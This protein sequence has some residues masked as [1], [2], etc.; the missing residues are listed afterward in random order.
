MGRRAADL[1]T[2]VPV[3]GVPALV[4][5][6]SWK[7]TGGDRSVGGALLQTYGIQ[8]NVGV[9]TSPGINRPPTTYC[10]KLP[11]SRVSVSSETSNGYFSVESVYKEI[12]L[13]T[14]SDREKRA[15]LKQKSGESKTKKEVTFKAGEPSKDV[16]SSRKSS[17]TYCYA[18]AI[19]TNP[20]L[21]GNS[22]NVR[23]KLKSITRYA[24]GS[25][26]DSEAIGGISIDNGDSE[27][28]S[29]GMDLNRQQ[30]HYAEQPGMTPPLFAAR[31]FPQKICSHC[32]GRQSESTRTVGEKSTTTHACSGKTLLNLNAPNLEKCSP[33]DAITQFFLNQ[34]IC[35][36]N[37]DAKYRN[38]PHP[39][40]PVHSLNRSFKTNLTTHRA[41]ITPPTTFFNSRSLTVTKATIE[42]RQCGTIPRPTSLPLTPLMATATKTNNTH[43]NTYPMHLKNLHK[44]T[45]EQHATSN[46]SKPCTSVAAIPKNIFLSNDLSITEGCKSEKITSVKTN[47]SNIPNPSKLEK[48]PYRLHSENTELIK[49]NIAQGTANL[50]DK[51]VMNTTSSKENPSSISLGTES[52]PQKATSFKVL[53]KS[54]SL[55]S[56]DTVN[57]K[58]NSARTHAL[59]YVTENTLCTHASTEHNCTKPVVTQISQTLP[60]L[61]TSTTSPNTTDNQGSLTSTALRST[62]PSNHTRSSQTCSASKSSVSQ[63]ALVEKQSLISKNLTSTTTTQENHV[64]P[65]DATDHV[66]TNT[67]L[68]RFKP[69]TTNSSKIQCFTDERKCNDNLMRGLVRQRSQDHKS[70]SGS[71]V[72]NLQNYISLIKSSSSCL[73]GHINTKQKPTHYQGYSKTELEGRATCPPVKTAAQKDPNT[74]QFALGVAISHEPIN[75]ESG[76]DERTHPASSASPV[77]KQEN[78]ISPMTNNRNSSISHSHLLSHSHSGQ[79]PASFHSKDRPHSVLECT[80]I[81]SSP[82]MHLA[83]VHSLEPSEAEE[84]VKGDSQSSFTPA[85]Q[86]SPEKASL[87]H[88]HPVDAAM[89][90]PASPQSCG[91]AALQQRLEC[92]EA[93]LAANKDRITTLLNIIHD[94]ETCQTPTSGYDV[95]MCKGSGM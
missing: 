21:A 82:T 11:E 46:T 70:S 38:T 51:S 60:Q 32:G 25:V 63:L 72:S 71:Q 20:Q 12:S 84:I 39:A 75:F 37:D 80:S 67:S 9:Q 34:Q 57:P 16:A 8:C 10:A 23:P 81:L 66:T 77:T 54:S 87:A 3:L 17:G 94:L 69:E 83:S 79:G 68:P 30:G 59:P 28:A 24:N 93:S 86:W 43:L 2:S 73:Q 62:L 65:N 29:C 47:K 4:G 92:V 48:E 74:E 91:S 61:C 44:S 56:P 36:P 26:V 49:T 15:I 52:A 41:N 76:R 13:L 50:S 19:K 31:P 6:R 33:R 78:N 14:K 90:L 45:I 58:A 95:C 42:T 85:P 27:S 18:R 40:C 89:M 1:T 22:A 5:L 55:T 7:T 53:T 88:S 35:Y 64:C